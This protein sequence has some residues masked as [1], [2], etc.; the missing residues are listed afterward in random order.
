MKYL[1]LLFFTLFTLGIFAQS[2]CSH[3]KAT[4]CSSKVEKTKEDWKKELSEDQFKVLC[5]GGTERPFTGEYL[6]NKKKGIYKCAACKNPLFSSDT[7]YDSGSGWPSFYNKID[8]KAIEEKIDYSHGMKR[9]EIV[10]S[11]CDGHLGHVF[12]DGPKPTGL[13]Y[14]VNSVSLEFEEVVEE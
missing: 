8:P 14:C 7:K 2:D 12:K 10:C 4:D 11:T 1:I 9:V 13:R 5:G 3:K 6:Y